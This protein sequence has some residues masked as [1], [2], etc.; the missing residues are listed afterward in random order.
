M[1]KLS[2]AQQR[3]RCTMI[4]SAGRAAQ[5]MYVHP[6]KAQ[7]QRMHTHKHAHVHTHTH[8]QVV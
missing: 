2:C 3:E 5:A 1:Y 6:P 8:L 4:K 7:K